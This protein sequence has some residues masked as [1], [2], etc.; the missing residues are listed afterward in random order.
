MLFDCISKER[1]CICC[2]INGKECRSAC[3]WTKEP[4]GRVLSCRLVR[5]LLISAQDLVEAGGCKEIEA[6]D[7]FLSSLLALLSR[8]GE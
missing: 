4:R 1:V 2:V 8:K 7:A 6:D 3:W 5:V